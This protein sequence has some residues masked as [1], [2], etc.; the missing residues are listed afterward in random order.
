MGIRLNKVTN[1][2]NIGIHTIVEFL[3]NHHI[4]PMQTPKKKRSNSKTEFSAKKR[5]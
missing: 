2:L 4:F 5:R 1:Q 3:K